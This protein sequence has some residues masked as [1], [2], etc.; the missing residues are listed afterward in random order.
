MVRLGQ[1]KM[2]FSN[3]RRSLLLTAPRDAIRARIYGMNPVL[4]LGP[5]DVD[6]LL[7]ELIE[8]RAELAETTT[9]RHLAQEEVTK[10]TNYG[11]RREYHHDIG[12]LT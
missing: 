1:S 12:H 10:K 3:R 9:K 2:I 4:V 6:L 7:A 5:K 8:W 11:R